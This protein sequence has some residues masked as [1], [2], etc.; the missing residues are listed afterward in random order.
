MKKAKYDIIYQNYDKIGGNGAD[1]YVSTFFKDDGIDSLSQ[2]TIG[3]KNNPVGS[4]TYSDYIIGLLLEKQ[5]L[6][7]NLQ[8]FENLLK[9]EIKKIKDVILTSYKKF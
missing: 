8:S 7:F 6:L 1:D 3:F 2:K 4:Y 5:N 9:N